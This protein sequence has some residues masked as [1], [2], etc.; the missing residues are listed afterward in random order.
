MLFNQKI[1]FSVF[2]SNK[3]MPRIL[4]FVKR[5]FKASKNV[6][7]TIRASNSLDPDKAEILMGLIWLQTVCKSYH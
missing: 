4:T 7:K 1:L 3:K 2:L 6:M 5:F